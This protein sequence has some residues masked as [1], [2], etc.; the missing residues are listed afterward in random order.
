M[1]LLQKESPQSKVTRSLPRGL[2]QNVQLFSASGSCPF[3]EGVGIWD[4]PFF[5]GRLALGLVV[6]AELARLAAWAGG[7]DTVDAPASGI[8]EG[9][10]GICKSLIFR[11]MGVG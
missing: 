9:V 8:F 1:Q 3:G 6:E 2:R 11:V 4:F 5:R 10:F 7:K